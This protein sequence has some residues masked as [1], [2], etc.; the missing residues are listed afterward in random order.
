[1]TVYTIEITEEAK[2]DL[3]FF[4]AFERKIIVTG[5]KQQLLHEPLNETKNRKRLREN[6]IASYELRIGWY[7]VFYDVVEDTV[8]VTVVS[9]GKK[10]NHILYIRNKEVKI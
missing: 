5:I 9:I 8:I 1:M 6:P 4:T 2:V 3:S 7:R 10:E